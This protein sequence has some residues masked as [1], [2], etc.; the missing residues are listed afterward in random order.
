MI[1]TK[2]YIKDKPYKDIY[3][4]YAKSRDPWLIERFFLRGWEYSAVVHFGKF[5][6]IDTVLDLGGAR[7]YL[8]P[9]IVSKYGCDGFIYD[10][11]VDYDG[12]YTYWLMTMATTKEY[13]DRK[14]IVMKGYASHLPFRENYFDKI[15][16]VSAFEHFPDFGDR[17]GDVSAAR[18]AYRALKPG[19]L[20]LGSVDFNPMSERLL[21][22]AMCYNLKTFMSR[23]VEAAPFKLV[24]D[25]IMPEWGKEEPDFLSPDFP[26]KVMQLFFI[27]TK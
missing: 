6:E 21:P 16:T 27:L 22:P 11:G 15:I 12:L 25:V 18:E 1:F 3:V 26:K 19:G 23:I 4:E 9:F 10:L 8:L 14:V 24:G 2:H 5:T 17:W 13:F 20:F 7:S